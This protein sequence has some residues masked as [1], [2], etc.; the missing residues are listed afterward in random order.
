MSVNKKN[1]WCN[2]YG[3]SKYIKNSKNSLLTRESFLLARFCTRW[4]L[5]SNVSASDC[6]SVLTTSISLSFSFCFSVLTPFFCFCLSAEEDHDHDLCDHLGSDTGLHPGWCSGHLILQ[7][8]APS[9]PFYSFCNWLWGKQNFRSFLFLPS[10]V[11]C[12]V[13]L[14]H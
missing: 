5:F 9:T 7:L 10:I 6:F 11:G 4:C 12:R 13:K 1:I 8:A 3:R 2:H 14:V